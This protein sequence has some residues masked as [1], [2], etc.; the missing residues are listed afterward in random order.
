MALFI[1]LNHFI[2]VNPLVDKYC[3]HWCED[4]AMVSFWFVLSFIQ[5]S[6]I[7]GVINKLMYNSC[8]LARDA[9]LGELAPLLDATL[10]EGGCAN[11]DPF[12]ASV[13]APVLTSQLDVELGQLHGPVQ[14]RSEKGQT[15]DCHSLAKSG[16]AAA[17][18]LPACFLGEGT[19]DLAAEPASCGA[20]LGRQED[21]MLFGDAESS[22]VD[23][24]VHVGHVAC[25]GLPSSDPAND[26][27]NAHAAPSVSEAM[28]P[29]S[30]RLGLGLGQVLPP[31]GPLSPQLGRAAPS[32]HPSQHPG[33]VRRRPCP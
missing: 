27:H 7:Q 25:V 10:T 8:T 31:D 22:H 9:A 15:A 13:Q 30:T 16:A 19:P 14:Q 17:A 24:T 23:F 20:E 6:H 29:G 1:I 26:A 5:S 18:R 11:S 32:P 21:Q 28:E 12:S 2:F 4:V 33:G 3:S